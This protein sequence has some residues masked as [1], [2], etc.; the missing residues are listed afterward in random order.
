MKSH[1]SLALILLAATQCIAQ[2]SIDTKFDTP[3][4]KH[5]KL[6]FRK[7]SGS[8][9]VPDAVAVSVDPQGVVYATQTKRR[10]IQDLDIRSH[11]EWIAD[12]VGLQSIEQK[13]EFF[14]RV[15]A[16]GGDEIEQA[17]HVQDFNKDGLH[18][19]RDLMVVSEVIYRLIDSDNDGLADKMTVFAE[20][21][22]TEVTGIAAGVL[23]YDGDVY[24]TV[25]PDLW[26]L[27]DDN[28]D[29]VADRR[30][31]LAHG[32]GHHIAYGGH[33]MHGPTVGPDGK[34]YWSIGDKGINLVTKK[35]RHIAYPNQGGVM[36]CDTD[37]SNFEVF[38]HGLRNVQEVAFDQY[39]NMFG[40]DND[41]DMNGERE[42][43]VYIVNQ[44][45]AGWR[46]N[47]QYRGKDYNPWM[48]E[49]L[50]EL[51]GEHHP[52]YII[53]PLAYAFDGP[54]GL[55]FNPGTAISDDYKDYF[56]ATGAPKGEQH[57]FKF[58]PNGDTFQIVD[59]HQ[60]GAGLAI[61]GLSFG[62]DGGLYGADWDGGY[63]MDEI[64]SVVR[65]DV[66]KE[67][68][69]P[70]RLQVAKMLATGFDQLAK[71]E[72][73]GLLSHPDQRV[74][75]GSQFALVKLHGEDVLESVATNQQ[76]H[77]LA[78]LH[79]VWGLGQL[80]RSDDSEANHAI[81]SLLDTKDAIVRGQ[82]AKTYGELKQVDGGLL[83]DLLDDENM[84]VRTL[85]G[86]ALSRQ[87]TSSAVD[88]LL[89]QADNLTTAQHYLR[90]SIALALAACATAEQLSS[91]ASSNNEHR[92]MCAVLALR[93]HASAEVSKFLKD[94]SDWVA[95]EA[96]RAIHDDG[97]IAAALP[98]LAASLTE[99]TSLPT[100]F[101]LRAINANFRSGDDVSA[102]R[103]LQFALNDAQAQ[104]LR[105]GA[106]Q[107][108]AQWFTP[109]LLDRV[110]GRRRDLKTDGRKIDPALFAAGLAKLADSTD[111]RI[112]A[113][114]LLA[115]RQLDVSL[116]NDVLVSLA[117]SETN[118]AEVRIESL[119]SLAAR[120]RDS[121]QAASQ[122]ELSDTMSSTLLQCLKSNS[123]DLKIRCV[124]LL[125]AFYPD[126]SVTILSDVISKS[127]SV[128]VKQAAIASLSKINNSSAQS[129]IKVLAE[130]LASGKIDAELALDVRDA[131][132]QFSELKD[133]VLLAEGKY[134]YSRDGGNIERGNELFSTHVAAQCTR[135]HKVGR[136]GSEIGPELTKISRTRDADY[137][138]RAIVEPS[139][140][141]D[142]KYRL[143][144]Y[145]MSSGEVVKGIPQ[146][147]NNIET[148]I[149]D[150]TGTL[151][152]LVTDDI[153]ESREQ[154]LSPMP[155]MTEILSAQQVRDLVA[156]LRSLK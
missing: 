55:K 126:T 132:S 120:L 11:R 21:F 76:A 136:K 40:I 25:A 26:K 9:N 100:A 114:T 119:N 45:D 19:W 71:S 155:N 134:A 138:L 75:Q 147:Q 66:P 87:P 140:D 48:E 78:R 124:E 131:L 54:A 28:G 143:Q 64:G 67:I 70:M 108:L 39:G 117:A 15:L 93:H 107:S 153:E 110:D 79:A 118:E 1:L 69:S 24:A 96:T 37:G 44:M 59:K 97:S 129:V 154:K 151:V 85:A 5:P 46:C 51:P 121:A 10:G 2:E 38:A 105:L 7:W 142:A 50:W 41:A 94:R 92:R 35:G 130:R 13:S 60:F 149:A 53:P 86:I 115:A 112:R 31:S 128:A 123:N 141:I 91:Q 146:K 8:I 27:H 89:K 57:A 82:A 133:N 98:M 52:A 65:I 23:A 150:S 106:L 122:P 156:Y 99:R 17:K 77:Q 14:K 63:P 88:T 58:K 90:H 148:I 29:G 34:I 47:Y 30:E 42:R 139:A 18:D 6:A 144:M 102:A 103:L 33:D 127:D 109:P 80:A 56:F 113:T 145:L 61:V 32:F 95:T 116:P 135:C 36:R 104:S 84:H 81:A 49:H 3:L 137:L 43:F 111:T 83:I 22:K 4:P 101:A 68:S 20:D 125:G 73:L 72:L 12:D 16:I 62:P 152:T 74:R